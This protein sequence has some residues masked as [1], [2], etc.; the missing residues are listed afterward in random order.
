MTILNKILLALL[1]TASTQLPVLA[2]VQ[3]TPVD[4]DNC[5]E[6][7]TQIKPFNIYGNT[8]Y[9][10]VQGLSA[11]LVTSPRGHILLD[12]GLPQ[13]LVQ[14]VVL[15]FPERGIGLNEIAGV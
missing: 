10:G 15:L 11:L 5:K 13:L 3:D 12:G 9:V 1:A 7:N 8:W 14:L 4:C 2:Q 6:W